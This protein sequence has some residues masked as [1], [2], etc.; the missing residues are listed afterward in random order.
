[1]TIFGETLYSW[2]AMMFDYCR[3]V[4]WKFFFHLD[5]SFFLLF[6]N[7][8]CNFT[9]SLV[10]HWNCIITNLACIIKV[11]FLILLL[12]LYPMCGMDAICWTRI[13][14]MRIIWM[15]VHLKG[16]EE[17][18]VSYF[19]PWNNADIGNVLLCMWI[20]VNLLFLVIS[21]ACFTHLVL[22]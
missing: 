12:A 3:E 5:S 17:S 20:V 9:D 19:A 2:D 22:D 10:P 7:F 15:Q 16:F 14:N 11:V 13:A 6:F 8:H 18:I 21:F 1:M 4:T